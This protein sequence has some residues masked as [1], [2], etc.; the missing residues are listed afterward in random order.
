MVDGTQMWLLKPIDRTKNIYG[1]NIKVNRI[2]ESIII[3]CVGKGF[4]VSDLNRGNISPQEI[5]YFNYPIKFGWQNEW[6]KFMKI[7]IISFQKFQADKLI[8]LEKLKTF[9]LNPTMEIFDSEYK[10]LS[11][12]TIAKLIEHIQSIDE[13][14]TISQEYVVSISINY[15][16]KL[17]FWD[18]QTNSGKM[19]ILSGY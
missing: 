12:D 4:D 19:K 17:V 13:N 3:E 8:R 14:W 18:I 1:I 11:F 10:P 6:W 9:G 7:K 5:V 15:D 16:G 2:T